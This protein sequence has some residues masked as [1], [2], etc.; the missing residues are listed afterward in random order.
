MAVSSKRQPCNYNDAQGCS[1]RYCGKEVA[2]D[3]QE[4]HKYQPFCSSRCKFADLDHWFEEDYRIPGKP[5]EE[6]GSVEEQLQ[7]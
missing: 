6:N 3:S 4:W 7:E 1:C 5:V 2:H